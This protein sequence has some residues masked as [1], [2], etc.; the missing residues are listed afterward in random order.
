MSVKSAL[1]NKKASLLI[2][3]ERKFKDIVIGVPHHA[4]GGVEKLPCAEHQESDENAGYL[5]RYVAKKLRS[6]S[7]IACNYP[8]DSNKY[9]RSDYSMQIASW[10]PKFLVEIHGHGGSKANSDIEISS[11]SKENNK[12]SEKLEQILLSKCSNLK[13][14]KNISICGKFEKIYFQ[15]TNSATIMDGRWIPFHIELH[16]ILRKSP[17][18]EMF[19]PPK[20]GFD[21]CDILVGALTEIC[22]VEC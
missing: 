4:P 1:G 20:I 9:F 21:F 15:A 16:S 7:I 3:E 22:R 8:I 5:G 2:V 10:N 6:C 12:W 18:S 17:E 11:G 13:E 19:K 14:L